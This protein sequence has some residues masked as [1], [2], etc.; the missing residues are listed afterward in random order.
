MRKILLLIAVVV[1]SSCNSNRDAKQNIQTVNPNDIQLGEV[2]HDSLTLDQIDKIKR[3][4]TTFEEVYPVSL[5]ETITNFKRDQNP[6]SEI[7]IWL[8]MADAYENYLNIK[9]GKLDLNAK[10]EVYKLIL[11]RSMMPDEQAIINSKLTILTEKEAKEVLGY[12]SAAPDP[13]DIVEKR[14]DLPSLVTPLSCDNKATS[15]DAGGLQI[16]LYQLR[17]INSHLHNVTY[18]NVVRH[19]I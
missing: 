12:Y 2:V 18:T 11:S 13:I 4:Q 5:E 16:N 3:I 17:I 8:Q 1:F 15:S 14:S 10:K 9:K 7:A 19:L 6:D